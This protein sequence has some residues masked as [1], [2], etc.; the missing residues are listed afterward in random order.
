[1]SGWIFR[2]KLMLF[3][4]GKNVKKSFFRNSGLEWKTLILT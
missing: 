2:A 4:Q 3:Q 1:M